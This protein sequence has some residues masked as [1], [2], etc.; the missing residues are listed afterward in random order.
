MDMKTKINKFFYLSI[1]LS[2]AFYITG[3]NHSVKKENSK[4]YQNMISKKFP[5]DKSLSDTFIVNNINEFEE[6]NLVIDK[7]GNYIVEGVRN[8][9][10]G[11]KGKFD[12]D[13]TNNQWIFIDSKGQEYKSGEFCIEVVKSNLEIGKLCFKVRDGNIIN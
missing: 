4:L 6:V 2:S 3:C 9:F 1:L 11:N 10:H 8:V 5:I 13:I 12:V 7:E